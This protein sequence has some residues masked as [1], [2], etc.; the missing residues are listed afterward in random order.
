MKSLLIPIAMMLVVP[1]GTCRAYEVRTHEQITEAALLSSRLESRLPN[2]G[3]KKVDQPLST[4]Q[5]TQINRWHFVACLAE[6]SP[7]RV[8]IMNMIRMGAFCEDV[9][10]GG[11]EQARFAFHFYDPAHGGAG[12]STPLGSFSS[13]LTW[14][15]EAAPIAT[16]EFSYVDLKAYLLNALT[17]GS[18]AEREHN[19]ALTFRALGHVLHLVQDLAQPQH[20]RD[21]SHGW[22]SAYEHYTD[23][24]IPLFRV[25]TNLPMSGY[26][27]PD[28]ALP[29]QL[30]HT[31]EGKGLADYS[32]R[33][34]V[35]AGTNFSSD[36]VIQPNR[37]FALPN[38]VG[39]Q[40][41]RRQVTD[42]DLLGPVSASQ[43]LT[44]EMWFVSTPVPDG[45]GNS[46]TRNERSSTLSLFDSDLQH[47][48]LG[49]RLSLNRFNFDAAHALLIPRAVAYSTALVDYLFRGELEIG[50]PE[51]G[52][53]SVTDHQPDACGTPCGFRKVKLTVRNSTS[54][55]ETMATGTLVLVA[56]YHLNNCYRPDL[57]GEDGGTGFTGR[58]CRSSEDYISVAV[59]QLVSGIGSASAQN[60]EFAFPLDKPIPINAS[61]LVLQLVFTGQLGEEKDAIAVATKDIAEPTYFA[62][63]NVSDYIYDEADAQY[64][65]YPYKNYRTGLDLTDAAMAFGAN[66]DTRRPLALMPRLGPGEHAQ[67]ALLM[68][69]GPQPS[70]FRVGGDYANTSDV[71]LVPF[72]PAE[73][74]VDDVG[75]GAGLYQRSCDVVPV[76][77]LFGDRG[78]TFNQ[79]VVLHRTGAAS[80]R[81]DTGQSSGVAARA[82]PVSS[83][84][85]GAGTKAARRANCFHPSE[86]TG[87]FTQMTPLSPL[88]AKPWLINF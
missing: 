57:S 4:E 34:F 23:L 49:M 46:S 76:R 65:A 68:E 71:A 12:A 26:A 38:G 24:D 54:S 79:E 44:G 8:S 22:M 10:I 50:L 25:R 82:L 52:V 63:F 69:R 41:V 6:Q 21:D 87:N 80:G 39:A 14:G 86:P 45:L 40:L 9:T 64:H 27:P 11:L 31:S 19:F 55:G 74:G 72:D 85:Q 30:W 43:P 84:A 53:F 48:G 75:S 51:E 58:A 16:Q 77:G 59:P 42:S 70:F 81:G 5:V 36:G 60:F 73:F 83:H 17:A 62:L 13:S 1:I 3:L 33:G 35:S 88:T 67:I 20:T 37:N 32:N 47:R 2:F 61:D 18:Q 29:D 78:R 66:A 7:A 15:L 28:I 56:K